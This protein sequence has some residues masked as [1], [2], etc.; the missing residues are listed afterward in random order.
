MECC[1]NLGQGVVDFVVDVVA[2][3]VSVVVVAVVFAHAGDVVLVDAAAANVAGVILRISLNS[4][5]RDLRPI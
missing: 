2:A 1:A 3:A 4:T 5:P